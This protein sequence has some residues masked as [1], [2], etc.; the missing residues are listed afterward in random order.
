MFFY[1][2][3][4]TSLLNKIQPGLFLDDGWNFKSDNTNSFWSKGYSTECNIHDSFI[5]IINGYVP[6]GL[7]TVIHYNGIEYKVYHSLLRGYPLYFKDKEVTNLPNLKD[8]QRHINVPEVSLNDDPLSLDEAV[9]QIQNILE[10]NIL[11][12]HQYNDA[13]LNVL[14]SGGLDTV[15]VW[16]L[17]DK[18]S[19]PYDFDVSISNIKSPELL[20]ALGRIR[21]YETP[22]TEHISKN[23]WSYEITSLRKNINWYSTGFYSEIMTLRS[24]PAFAIIAGYYNKTVYDFISESDYV[25]SFLQRKR[26]IFDKVYNAPVDE[27]SLKE[28]LVK[29]I[30]SDY[31]MWHIDNNFHFSPFYDIR[32]AQVAYRL[33]IDDLIVNSRHGTIQRMIIE[34]TNPQLLKLVSD[35]KN[36][37]NVMLNFMRNLATIKFPKDTKKTFR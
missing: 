30:F 25:Y 7:W 3:E 37:G 27:I 4:H 26:D 6:R 19:I 11:G 35:K 12:F 14:F 9:N 21:E 17:I 24:M 20:K 22:L 28:R 5:D 15:I 29:M 32:I 36:T 8:F 31:Q 16:A 13:R 33:S 1:I 2:G 18:L 10:E 23:V 34:R